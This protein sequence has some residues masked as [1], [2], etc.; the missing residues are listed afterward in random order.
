[1]S[2]KNPKKKMKPARPAPKP[3][4]VAPVAAKQPKKGK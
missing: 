2:D 3:E 1:M 4:P